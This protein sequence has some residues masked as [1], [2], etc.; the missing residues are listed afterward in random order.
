MKDWFKSNSKQ[1][2]KTL[3]KCE[4]VKFKNFDRK[5]KSPFMIYSD[6]ESILER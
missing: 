5:V 4:H 3:K 6:F 2:I 1:T